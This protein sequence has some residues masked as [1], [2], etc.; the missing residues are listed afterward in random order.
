MIE[1]DWPEP[2]FHNGDMVIFTP[3]PECMGRC[4]HCNT[5][6]NL[7]GLDTNPKLYPMKATIWDVLPEDVEASFPCYKCASTTEA[8]F[9]GHR[10][11]IRPFLYFGLIVVS[12]AELKLVPVLAPDISVE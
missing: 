7:H 11:V 8:P 5:I 1:L 3:N 10:I 12:G 4:S 9:S 2:E 6:Q